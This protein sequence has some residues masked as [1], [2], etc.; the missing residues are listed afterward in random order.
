MSIRKADISANTI[1]RAAK[2]HG[3]TH[4]SV[5]GSRAHGAGTPSSD[6]DLLVDMKPG[7][8][9]LDLVGFKLDLEDA[10]GR[11]VD[12]VTRR[13]LSPYLRRHI[14]RQARPLS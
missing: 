2:V 10:F 8:D 3:V 12:V 11:P 7:R 14:L 5:F 4:V 13:G 1:R 9:L 6:L